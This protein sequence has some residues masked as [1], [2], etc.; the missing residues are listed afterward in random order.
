MLR[1]TFSLAVVIAVAAPMAGATAQT[2]APPTTA[3]AQSR[4]VT[5]FDCDAAIRPDETTVCSSPD[6]AAMDVQL[7]TLQTVVKKFVSPAETRDL[8][9]GRAA[10]IVH[11]ADQ[12]AQSGETS[13]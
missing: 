12:D 5:S 1:T 4:L 11:Q 10:F 7:S 13:Q 3:P 8:N 9:A 2:P 6:L